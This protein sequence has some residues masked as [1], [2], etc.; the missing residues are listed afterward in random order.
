MAK[1]AII[2]GSGFES[3]N[4]KGAV[5]LQRHGKG[6]CVPPHKI[7]HRENILSLKK[8]GCEA[9]IGVNSVGSLKKEIAPGSI[10]IPDDYINLKNIQ[11]YYDL[12]V[13]HITPGLDENLRQEIIDAAGKI[14]AA[15]VENGVYIQ[16]IGP[17]LE[18]KA[19]INMLKNYGDVVGMTMANEATL[20]RELGLKYASIC[21]VDNYAHGISKEE[22]TFEN[23]CAAQKKN[24]EKIVK[25]LNELLGKKTKS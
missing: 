20:A 19:E 5:F 6:S 12:E 18:T 17:R 21:S 10:V 11:T 9:I 16:T 13:K 14:N 22:V 15:V 23:I 7:N 8:S 2:G 1:I 24:R 3:F 25:I 4:K